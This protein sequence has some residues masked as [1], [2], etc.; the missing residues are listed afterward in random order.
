MK[1]YKKVTMMSERELLEELVEDKR[2]K[3]RIRWIK[4][5]LL[6]IV[7]L[8]AGYYIY[9]TLS[10]VMEVVNQYNG[11]MQEINQNVE[12]F[13]EYFDGDGQQTMEG[14]QNILQQIEEFS[15]GFGGLFGH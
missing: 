12:S 6:A 2:K 7:I 10:R 1:E 8:V 13:K 9:T 3:D 11:M 15:N 14:L 4:Y 5:A